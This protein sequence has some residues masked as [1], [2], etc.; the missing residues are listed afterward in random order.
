MFGPG[1][2]PGMDRIVGVLRM[3]QQEEKVRL[4]AKAA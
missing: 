2:N 4:T 3:L 1:G